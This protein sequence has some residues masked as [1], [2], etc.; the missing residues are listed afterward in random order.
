[1]RGVRVSET[2]FA[3]DPVW[4]VRASELKALLGDAANERVTIVDAETQDDLERAVAEMR[5]RDGD[6]VAVGSGA[7]AVAVAGKRIRREEP[8]VLPAGPV[9][10]VCGSGHPLNRIQAERLRSE[11][12]VS[13]REVTLLGR[14]ASPS[15]GKE[16]VLM[17]EA[18]R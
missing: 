6:W 11:R 13:V 8:N 3:R 18:A 7:L 16:G 17:I 15:F 10:V 14:G 2:E 1:M 4:P 9:W 5:E 12:G